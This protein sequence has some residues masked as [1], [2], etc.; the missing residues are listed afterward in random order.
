MFKL[1][2][3]L[4]GPFSIAAIFTSFI[5]ILKYPFDINWA[6]YDP[7]YHAIH[8]LSYVS[9]FSLKLPL[10]TYFSE[11]PTDPWFL[12][13]IAIA[14]T[15]KLMNLFAYTDIMLAMQVFQILSV[16]L[17]T[18]TLLWAYKVF[19]NFINNQ[20]QEISYL[21]YFAL[22]LTVFFF[23]EAFTVRAFFFE[24]PHTL[25]ISLT[26]LAAIAVAKRNYYLLFA[27]SLLAPLTYSFSFFVFIPLASFYL[28]WLLLNL[29]L[30]FPKKILKLSTTAVSGFLIGVF[31]HPGN[32]GYLINGLGFHSFAIFQSLF[33][34]LPV[35]AGDL[36]IPA[37]MVF[38]TDNLPILYS[39]FVVILIL[40]VKLLS[41]DKCFPGY[42][43]AG[44][45]KAYIAGW[46][47]MSIILLVSSLLVLRTVEYATPFSVIAVFASLPLII[48][49][50]KKVWDDA[51]IG[52][53]TKVASFIKRIGEDLNKVLRF[54][55]SLFTLLLFTTFICL[56]LSISKYLEFKGNITYTVN[57]NKPAAE[58]L[59]ENVLEDEVVL[60]S[61]FDIYPSLIYF[62]PNLNYSIG[63]DVRM[64][65]FY[66]PALSLY[67]S[68]FFKTG[69][70]YKECPYTQDEALQE[71]KL[72]YNIGYVFVKY[73]EEN[74]DEID[75]FI[76]NSAF[77]LVFED[78]EARVLIFK[79]KD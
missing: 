57:E 66:D 53:E 5:A 44:F 30:K 59:L 42:N 38:M 7:P 62:A 77:Q 3:F 9:D 64:V 49:H 6:A 11:Y 29:N 75:Y 39:L 68:A 23:F 54:K 55:K 25:M 37:E 18:T 19:S 8:S 69:E 21:N 50:S 33:W 41:E 79:L 74:I 15:Y 70:C 14:A 40:I 46:A 22:L 61:S 73:L 35:Q 43:D 76:D 65:Y 34:W 28:G 4:R 60:L 67:N 26:L 31:L 63:M 16:F 36:V 52:N 78:K 1:K 17:F 72:R 45:S 32:I 27:V 10:F 12:H 47:G 58:F 13:H 24:R 71:L 48:S 51:F 20:N 56:T 2:V